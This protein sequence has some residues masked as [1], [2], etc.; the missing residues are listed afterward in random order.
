MKLSKKQKRALISIPV[1]FVLATGAF[2]LFEW[3]MGAEQDAICRAF[4]AGVAVA[5]SGCLFPLLSLL[6]NWPMKLKD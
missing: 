4:W 5:A 2:P 1:V 6:F 3:L